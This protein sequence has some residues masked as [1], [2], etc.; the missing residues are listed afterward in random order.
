MT[1]C[2]PDSFLAGVAAAFAVRLIIDAVILFQV[3]KARRKADEGL[4]R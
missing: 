3:R 1:D 4:P 2:T